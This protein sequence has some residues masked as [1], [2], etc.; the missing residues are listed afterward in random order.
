MAVDSNLVTQV[1]VT[2]TAAFDGVAVDLRGGT[3]LQGLG[4]RVIYKNAATS[5]G[6]GAVTFGIQ[7]SADGVTW[8]TRTQADPIAL[9]TVATSG[10][11]VIP[12]QTRNRYIRLS[13]LAI[14]GTGATVGYSGDV[15]LAVR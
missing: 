12:V 2:K 3:P 6:A 11:I 1:D 5:A 9:G 13:L 14:S 4:V 8:T 7:H 15:Q 10:E